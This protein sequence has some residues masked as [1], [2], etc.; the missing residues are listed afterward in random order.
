MSRA[1]GSFFILIVSIQ[2]I[3]TDE[4]FQNLV[5]ERL[6]K[7]ESENERLSQDNVRLGSKVEDL[8]KKLE[9]YKLVSFQSKYELQIVQD[10]LKDSNQKTN[11]HGE[12][13]IKL[14]S[15]VNHLKDVTLSL[16]TAKA[17]WQIA[18]QV[19]TNFKIIS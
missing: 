7:L 17:C 5:L 16:T 3:F 10:A 9:R 14:D 6:E 1:I 12:D 19:C 4:E 8:G 15:N 11:Q 18:S 13:L 2:Q